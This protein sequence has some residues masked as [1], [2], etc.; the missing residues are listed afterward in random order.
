MPPPS[1]SLPLP[2]LSF[3]R[4]LCTLLLAAGREEGRPV[5]EEE[6]VG[7][8]EGGRGGRGVVLSSGGGVERMGGGASRLLVKWET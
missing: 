5:E 2:L 1:P 6:E 8:G 7:K 4:P 3:H